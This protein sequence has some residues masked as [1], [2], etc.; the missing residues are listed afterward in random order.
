MLKV[1]SY[2][3]NK[4]KGAKA[5]LYKRIGIPTGGNCVGLVLRKSRGFPGAVAI[6]RANTAV[7]TLGVPL[8]V[9]CHLVF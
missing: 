7:E 9:S 5:G 6:L 2:F 8:E 3:R 1:C 4:E